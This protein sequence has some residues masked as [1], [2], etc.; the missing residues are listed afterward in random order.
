MKDLREMVLEHFDGMDD[1]MLA[2]IGCIQKYVDSK[3]EPELELKVK[4]SESAKRFP[5][6]HV[7][8]DGDVGYDLTATLEESVTVAP[9]GGRVKIPTGV[10][11]E[12]PKGWWVSIE[13]RS[14]T[15]EVKLIVPKGVIDE[16]YRGELLAVLL[17]IGQEPVVI[18]DGDRL[19]QVI[20]H[21]KHNTKLIIT[22]VDELS[23]SDRGDTGFG[24]S[25]K[26][27]VEVA[28]IEEEV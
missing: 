4:R 6:I 2:L 7:K 19:V 12:I 11:L 10:F 14:S 18:N 28:T 15:S 3:V 9:N 21:K 26:K 25:G 1:E 22:E 13:A 27:E 5:L 16:G 20:F 17:N 8:K 23:A 24:S